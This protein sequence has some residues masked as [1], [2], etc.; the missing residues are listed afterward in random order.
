[1]SLITITIASP[2]SDPDKFFLIRADMPEVDTEYVWC[3]QALGWIV[4]GPLAVKHRKLY[5]S[6]E[7][8]EDAASRLVHRKVG[9]KPGGN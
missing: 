8:A 5:D 1:M 7:D 3:G 9:R 2:V 4:A 6:F